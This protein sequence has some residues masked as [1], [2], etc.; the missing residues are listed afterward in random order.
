MARA[1]KRLRR[2]PASRRAPDIGLQ[3]VAETAIV[4]AERFD[5]VNHAG[6]RGALETGGKEPALEDTAFSQDEIS[7]SSK[8]VVHSPEVTEGQGQL[9]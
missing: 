6:G 7:P 1:G 4:V 8:F 9:S 3:S 5:G 2:P